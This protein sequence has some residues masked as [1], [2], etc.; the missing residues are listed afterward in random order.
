MKLLDAI[1]DAKIYGIIREEDPKHAL[2][3]A[4]AYIE[5]GLKFIELNSPIEAMRTISKNTDAILV[6]GGV[7]T[8]N[9]A[10]VA[11][12]A[13]A[14]MI[15]SPILQSSLIRLAICK[16]IPLIP[17]VTT[18]NEAYTAWK[19]RISLVKIYPISPLGGVGYFKDII[20]PMPFL[21]LL[22]CGFVRIKDIKDYLKLGAMAVGIGRDF[23][24]GKSYKEIVSTIKE[25]IR[26]I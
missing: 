24:K 26:T 11:I 8:R 21:N 13:G 3:I 15:S 22:P 14:K 19:S 17:S 25:T 2:E 23:Y 20:R 7:I 9:Q 5:G 4:A 6:Q 18:P 10:E 1:K 12:E 16:K